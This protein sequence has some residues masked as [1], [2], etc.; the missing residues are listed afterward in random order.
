MFIGKGYAYYQVWPCFGLVIPETQS[1]PE[2]LDAICLKVDRH[3][4][5][6]LSSRVSIRLSREPITRHQ[7]R[8]IHIYKSRLHLAYSRW[9]FLLIRCIHAKSKHY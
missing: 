3:V 9:V 6:R 2:R 4:H 7:K 1:V 5:M 8:D